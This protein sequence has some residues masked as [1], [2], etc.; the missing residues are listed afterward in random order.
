MSDMSSLIGSGVSLPP[1][2][3]QQ[4]MAQ[5]NPRMPEDQR[6]LNSMGLTINSYA[7]EGNTERLTNDAL[8]TRFKLIDALVAG[9]EVPGNHTSSD[10]TEPQVGIHVD[11]EPLSDLG[12]A[13][14]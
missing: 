5:Q 11:G 1:G 8:A 9:E 3:A 4:L 13:V 14:L 6:R 10:T 12:D 2:V 7:V